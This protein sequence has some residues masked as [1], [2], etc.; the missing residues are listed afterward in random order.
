MKS[1]E[2]YVRK[3]ILQQADENRRL[4]SITDTEAN[5]KLL[6]ILLQKCCQAVIL[7]N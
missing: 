2:R 1:A 7:N 6:Q 4:D 3:L 5:G